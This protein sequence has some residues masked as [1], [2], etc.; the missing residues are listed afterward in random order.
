MDTKP[1]RLS[2]RI[3]SVNGGHARIGVWQNGGKAGDLTVDDWAATLVVDQ[4]MRDMPSVDDPFVAHDRE[5]G[6][7][8]GPGTGG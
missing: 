2:A 6:L 4:I 8:V 5:A 3:I 1:F 7:P